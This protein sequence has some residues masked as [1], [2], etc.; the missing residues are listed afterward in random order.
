MRTADW[1]AGVTAW[2]GVALSE[3]AAGTPHYVAPDSPNPTPP[4]LFSGVDG[5]TYFLERSTDLGAS[6][7]FTPLATNI[8][9]RF[10][11]K[12]YPD[13]NATSIPTLIYCLG[14][15]D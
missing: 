8:P 1:V 15:A 13:T 2:V 9:G 3:V 7:T 6:P 5:V 10:R 11:T 4:F 14:G 12:S